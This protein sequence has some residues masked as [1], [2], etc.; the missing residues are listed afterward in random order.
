[1]NKIKMMN[2]VLQS[3]RDMGADEYDVAVEAIVCT[4]NPKYL[5]HWFKF[6]DETR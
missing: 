6:L 3:F 5:V 2:F 1:M 4:K